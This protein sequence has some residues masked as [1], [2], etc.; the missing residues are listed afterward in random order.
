[1]AFM[2]EETF[3]KADMLRGGILPLLMQARQ[4]LTL[5]SRHV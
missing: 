5:Q 1:M 3:A 4:S 2:R